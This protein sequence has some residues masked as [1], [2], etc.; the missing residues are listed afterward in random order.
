MVEHA[1]LGIMLTTSTGERP[2]PT[3]RLALLCGLT[4]EQA[5]ERGPILSLHPGTTA[6]AWCGNWRRRAG[7][8]R[9]NNSTGTLPATRDGSMGLVGGTTAPIVVDGDLSAH[10]AS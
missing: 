8:A 9:R 6:S 5:R 7:S 10:R 4:A 2:T 3:P 1:S